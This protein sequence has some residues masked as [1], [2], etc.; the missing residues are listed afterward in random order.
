MEIKRKGCYAYGSDLEPHKNQSSQIIAIAAEQHL[1]YQR[2][3]MEVIKEHKDMF[4]F[5]ITVKV[6]RS[7]SLLLNN[8]QVQKTGRVYAS[9]TGGR[10]TKIMPPSGEL[11]QY[12]RKPKLTDKYFNSIIDIIGNDVWD[13][14]IHT[15]NKS[16]YEFRKSDLLS[17]QNVTLCNDI[18]DF[19]FDNIDYQWYYNET[20]KITEIFKE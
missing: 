4:D 8:V 16:V 20:L 12:K 10:L 19:N 3:I 5:M 18:K 1:I 9:I 7:N 17:G 13:E 6:P 11:G 15:K 14:R 2:D